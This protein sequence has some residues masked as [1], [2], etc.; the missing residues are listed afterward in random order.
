MVREAR[1]TVTAICVIVGTALVAVPR[2]QTARTS[3]QAHLSRA[4][5]AVL[6]LKSAQF[7][8]TR[9]G[10]PAFLDEKAGITFTTAQ[11]IYAAPDRVSE[12]WNHFEDHETK[13]RST[14]IHHPINP[15]PRNA[16]FRGVAFVRHRRAS[17]ANPRGH[18]TS[19]ATGH[20]ASRAQ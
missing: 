10:T 6:N 17:G 18:T 7:T 2:A 9:E 14:R 19:D 11:C 12:D 16:R 4:A 1:E 13:S 3:P 15:R 20:D 5:D 8:I